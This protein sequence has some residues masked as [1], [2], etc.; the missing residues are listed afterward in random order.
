MSDQMGMMGG[1][2]S[3]ETEQATIVGP[4]PGGSPPEAPPE[5]PSEPQE[6]EDEAVEGVV[7]SA[8][9]DKL[10]P[11]SVL[12]RT[13][14]DLKAAKEAA[15]EAETLREQAKVAQERDRQLEQLRPL[16]DKLRQ[17]PDVVQALLSGQ[18]PPAPAPRGEP[19]PAVDP[20]EALLAKADAEDLA[21]TLELYTPE[22]QPDINRARKIAA[23]MRR[24]SDEE[25]ARR[26]APIAQTFA[27]GQ[28]GTL[29]QQYAGMKDKQGRTVNP[30]VLEQLWNLVPAELIAQDPKVA[31][32]LYYASKGYAQHHGLDEPVPPPR[33]PL[34]TEPAGGS[35]DRSK[36]VLT[37]F[38]QALRRA[39]QVSEKDY[40]EAA[41]R[42]KP[43][44]INKLE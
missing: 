32:I 18:E 24:T 7:Q 33:A 35:P 10:V 4:P 8:T 41:A 39:M 40:T 15:K 14:E 25:A 13:R 37:D 19:Q 20:G 28:A 42:Y 11:L 9:G 44:A 12:K 5:A 29:K 2:V 17:R 21:R 43:G 3:L 6:G 27:Q 23:V 34:M 31:G 30:Q 36:P 38:D 1:P 22:G 16:F 26:I